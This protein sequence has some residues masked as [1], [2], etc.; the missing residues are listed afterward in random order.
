MNIFSFIKNEKTR[1]L[2][3]I[4]FELIIIGLLGIVLLLISNNFIIL[5]PSKLAFR[6]IGTI[7]QLLVLLLFLYIK[8]TSV[9]DIGLSWKSI[10]PKYKVY[11]IIGLSLI[12]LLIIS[13]CFFM[14]FFAFAM[15]LRFGIMAALF[16][17]IIFRGYIWH[18][19]Q[20]KKFDDIT[21]IFTTAIFF[22][23]FHLTYY[24]EIGYATSFFNDAPSLSSILRQKVMANLGYGLFL[25]FFR[26][27]SKNLYLPLIIHSIGNILGQ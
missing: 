25:G 11:Y 5:N 9:Q 26:Y 21:L 7:V 22:G 14:P 3:N 13:A 27:K 4:I 19:L 16:E 24:Y 23:L 10:S 6:I 12:P 17:E 18:R 15:N 1:V 8:S 20:D 2:F